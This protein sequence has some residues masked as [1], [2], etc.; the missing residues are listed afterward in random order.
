MFDIM[1]RALSVVALLSAVTSSH[2]AGFACESETS[3]L[4]ARAN[5]LKT[6]YS[7]DDATAIANLTHSSLIR[8]AGGRSRLIEMTNAAMKK[9]RADH[10]QVEKYDI[11][12]PSKTYVAGA[13]YV[14]FL[15]RESVMS[16][17]GLRVRELGFLVAIR[18]AAP[19]SPWLFLDSAG[20][21]EKPE[22][23]WKLLPNLPRDVETPANSVTVLQ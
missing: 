15:P 5:V 21:R 20:L 18:D 19:S 17:P 23:L 4:L 16:S 3:V 10:I 22:V 6:A 8:L 9:L 7:R 1:N 14:C 12:P 11:F 13:D 2:A